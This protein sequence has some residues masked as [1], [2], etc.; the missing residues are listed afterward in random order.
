VR[1][2]EL[3]LQR[4]KQI[5]ASELARIQATQDMLQENQ[6]N[7]MRKAE[8]VAKVKTRRNLNITIVI[9]AAVALLI[10]LVE[11]RCFKCFSLF[12]SSRRYRVAQKMAQFFLVRLNFIK[13]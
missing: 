3:T 9:V 12:Q 2:L 7:E 6:R 8:L 11:R 10:A 5:H 1:E 13:Y 4:E